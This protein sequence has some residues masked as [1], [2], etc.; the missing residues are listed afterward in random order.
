MIF[1]V[2]FKVG[3]DS[4]WV[5]RIL[6]HLGFLREAYKWG[7]LMYVKD[8]FFLVIIFHL[9]VIFEASNGETLLTFF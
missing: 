2:R 4:Y 6:V 5:I 8:S 7:Y 1:F 9:F 3:F